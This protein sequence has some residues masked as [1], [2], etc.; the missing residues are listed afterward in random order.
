M[1]QAENLWTI[2]EID[3]LIKNYEKIGPKKCSEIINRTIRGCQLKSKKLNLKFNKIKEYY[4]RENLEKIIKESF[5][6]TSCLKKIGLS[7][8]PG[9]YDTLKKYIKLYNID[10]DHFYTDK[11]QGM[12]NYSLNIKI[13]TIDILVENSPFNRRSLKDRIYKEGLKERKCELCGQGE[14]WMGKKMS[15]ILDHINGVN[16][17]NRLENLRIVCPNCNSTLET[18]CGRNMKKINSNHDQ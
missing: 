11:K 18:H 14:E 7:N 1:K 16:D 4:E 6:Y 12:L 10:I 9:N 2:E 13:P 3:F 5:S 17:D 8:R 15:L